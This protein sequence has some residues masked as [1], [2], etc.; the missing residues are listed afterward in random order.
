M[1]PNFLLLTKQAID[2]AKSLTLRQNEQLFKLNK[3]QCKYVAQKLSESGEVLRVLKFAVDESVVC[4]C[5]AA[6]K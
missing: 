1:A 3:R 2:S 4:N 6:L 5:E